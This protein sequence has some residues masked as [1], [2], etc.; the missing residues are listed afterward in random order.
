MEDAWLRLD[1]GVPASIRGSEE[2]PCFS[3]YFISQ[4]V[5][6]ELYLY[7]TAFLEVVNSILVW[8]D[9]RGFQRPIYYTS[10]V[11]HDAET[12]YSRPEKIIFLLIISTQCLRS[13][14]QAHSIVILRNGMKEEVIGVG[15]YQLKMHN[16]H[17]LLLH[18]MLYA[19]GVRCNLC[20]VLALSGFDFSFHFS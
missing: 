16:E 11:L 13:Y 8:M 7:L 9:D 4:E 1:E 5:R 18:G 15:L 19:L 10:G 3:P 20:L 2:L 14:F 17:M 12:K 6:E